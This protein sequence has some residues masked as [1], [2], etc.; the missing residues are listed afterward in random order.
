[1]AQLLNE[2]V[3]MDDECGHQCNDEQPGGTGNHLLTIPRKSASAL[4]R[5]MRPGGVYE[6]RGD[7][8]TS[9]A[10]GGLLSANCRYSSF[11]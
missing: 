10:S 1:M 7:S 3:Q 2:L 11:R 4:G 8:I 6:T 5:I 9:A